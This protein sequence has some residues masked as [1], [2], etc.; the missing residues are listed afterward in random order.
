MRKTISRLPKLLPILVPALALFGCDGGTGS[1]AASEGGDFF[2]AAVEG[3]AFKA[4]SISIAA[5]PVPG[6]PGSIFFLGTQT[7]GG[8]QTSITVTLYNITGPGEFPLGTGA[9]VSGGTG[10]IGESKGSGGDADSW[11]TMENGRAGKVK[12]TRISDGRLAGTFEFTADPGH[13]NTAGGTRSVTDGKFDLPYKG[14][15]VP[16]PGD[17]GGRVSAVLNGKPY[18]AGYVEGSLLVYTGGPGIRF[19]STNSENGISITLEGVTKPETLSLANKA[20][21]R[22]ITAGRNG[23]TAEFCCWDSNAASTGTIIVTSVTATRVKGTFSGVI[24]PQSGKPAKED[25]V[26]ENGVFDIGVRPGL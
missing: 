21:I 6:V 14:A 23:G 17:K 13:T 8:Q 7:S 24:K 4:A 9:T 11:I 5:Q 26:I 20:P 15:F 12:L 3:K 1:G 25:L 22:T 18:N 19:S 16:A 2:T 10:Q